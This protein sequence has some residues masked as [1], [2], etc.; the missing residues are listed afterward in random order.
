[1]VRPNLPPDW[2][3]AVSCTTPQ[4]RL[5]HQLV[6]VYELRQFALTDSF[7]PREE[8]GQAVHPAAYDCAGL[9]VSLA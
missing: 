8:A 5:V 1:M 4:N 7:Q 2:W 6:H 9:P 3:D